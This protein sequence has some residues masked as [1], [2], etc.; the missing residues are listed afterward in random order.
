MNKKKDESSDI[1][2]VIEGKVADL[3]LFNRNVKWQLEADRLSIKRF[4]DS[5]EID[6][7]T[8]SFKLFA[9]FLDLYL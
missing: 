2:M 4:S 7:L 6:H 3:H 1:C 9:D 8:G 5:R